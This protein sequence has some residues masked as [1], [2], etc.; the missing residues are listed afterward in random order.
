ME[1]SFQVLAKAGR[2][3]A[4]PGP[5]SRHLVDRSNPERQRSGWGGEL[6]AGA[7]NQLRLLLRSGPATWRVSLLKSVAFCFN[8][9]DEELMER[10]KNISK[11][12]LV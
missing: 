10:N 4:T 7:T 2:V 11:I 5:A 9:S 1:N 8:P 6:A 3:S 12:A